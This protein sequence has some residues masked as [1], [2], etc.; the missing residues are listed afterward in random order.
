MG[1]ITPCF[2]DAPPVPQWSE[3]VP[4]RYINPS[5]S[6]LVPAL[7]KKRKALIISSGLLNPFLPVIVFAM[8]KKTEKELLDLK[9]YWTRRKTQFDNEVATCDATTA[10]KA[11]CFMQLRQMEGDKNKTY[12]QWQMQANLLDATDSLA[13]AQSNHTVCQAIGNMTSCDNH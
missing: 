3:F 11:M 12:S 4:T 9:E 6:P 13:K 8:R 1:I 2:P 5:L 10:D 7:S